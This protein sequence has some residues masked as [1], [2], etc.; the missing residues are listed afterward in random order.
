MVLYPLCSSSLSSWSCLSPQHSSFVFLLSHFF[1]YTLVY[2][3]YPDPSVASP[4]EVGSCLSLD[5]H[6]H[7][8]GETWN[9]GCRQC[10]C[11]NGQEMCSLISCPAIACASPTI[12]PGHC[13]P[14]C[15][16]ES[17]PH[18][19]DLQTSQTS[20]R[21][22]A[23]HLAF[24]LASEGDYFAEGKTWSLDSCTQCTCLAGQVLCEN[25]VCPALLCQN[26]IRTQDSCCPQCPVELHPLTPSNRSLPGYCRDKL[27]SIFLEAESWRPNPC[28]SCICLYGAIKCVPE[29]CPPVSCAEPVLH[30]GQ[31][32]P[33]CLGDVVSTAVCH[34]N[35]KTY[36]DEERWDVDV[37]TRCYCLQG[38]T[39]CSTV[40]CP[41]PRCRVPTQSGRCCP[42]C[43]E[44]NASTS[45]LIAK[46]EQQ[47][48]SLVPFSVRPTEG[49]SGLLPLLGGHFGSLWHFEGRVPSVSAFHS[50]AWTTLPLVMVLTAISALIVICKR[51]RRLHI[52][53]SN[54]P[55]Q[56]GYVGCHK[57]MKVDSQCDLQPADPDSA[58]VS[59]FEI[60]QHNNLQ[61]D[62]FYQTV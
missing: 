53:S 11:Y 60:Q 1:H 61:A 41:T 31:C 17:A 37:C 33:Y 55:T 58:H 9:D 6:H 25:K 8:E 19:N 49:D 29:F 54:T 42:V 40:S 47:L 30:K 20:H 38:Q 34:F 35:G 24:C 27:G 2:C 57:G 50:V 5:G 45:K 46:A 36:A 48:S 22:H 3:L 51:W 44:V 43:P 14:S 39:L 10:Y 21:G 15:P 4:T 18:N 13:C 28:S 26:P 16:C 59:Y 62:C 12:R 7:G 52:L 32:C 56:L 23:K